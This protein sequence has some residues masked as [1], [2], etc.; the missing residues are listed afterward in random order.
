MVIYTQRAKRISVFATGLPLLHFLLLLSALPAPQVGHDLPAVKSGDPTAITLRSSTNDQDHGSTGRSP[1]ALTPVHGQYSALDSK[2]V[3]ALPDLWTTADARELTT[4]EATVPG[5]VPPKSM[6][7]N[8][9]SLQEAVAG[10][11]N[12]PVQK[13]TNSSIEL[14]TMD[15]ANKEIEATETNRAPRSSTDH[16]HDGGGFRVGTAFNIMAAIV[17]LLIILGKGAHG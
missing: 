7:A 5:A 15:M 1:N 14:L 3:D 17:I 11:T 8:A 13:V 12:E 6:G 16:Q 4:S 10:L 9:I 2:Q